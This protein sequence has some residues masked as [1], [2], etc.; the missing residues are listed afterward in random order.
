MFS[1]YGVERRVLKGPRWLQIKGLEEPDLPGKSRAERLRLELKEWIEQ[2]ELDH[3]LPGSLLNR[4]AVLSLLESESKRSERFQRVARERLESVES[5]PNERHK[6]ESLERRS[7]PRSLFRRRRPNDSSTM[8]ELGPFFRPLSFFLFLLTREQREHWY[9]IQAD[10]VDDLKEMRQAG[11]GRFALHAKIA[12]EAVI[13]LTGLFL[14]R[15]LKLVPF[16]EFIG[17][18]FT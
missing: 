2:Y 7:R 17:R 9:Y 6:C 4:Q 13:E 15:L 18:W 5:E 3:K 8:V 16:G 12:W 11:H 1:R 10:L 14:K